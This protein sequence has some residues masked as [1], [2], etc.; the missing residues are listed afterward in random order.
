MP[1]KKNLG[2]VPTDIKAER[3]AAKKSEKAAKKV[4][5][6]DRKKAALHGA[7]NKAETKRILKIAELEHDI[8]KLDKERVKLETKHTLSLGKIAKKREKKAQK[9]AALRESKNQ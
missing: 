9:L 3:K 1:K 2:G 5:K 6:Q 8:I 4:E 7:P